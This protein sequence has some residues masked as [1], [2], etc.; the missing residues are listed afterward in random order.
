MRQYLQTAAISLVLSMGTLLPLHASAGPDNRWYIDSVC[1][2][3]EAGVCEKM[4]LSALEPLSQA[5]IAT[6]ICDGAFNSAMR[7]GCLTKAQSFMSRRDHSL[8]TG[9]NHFANALCDAREK[10][11]EER[12][13]CRGRIIDLPATDA[14]IA[15][16]ICKES[17]HLD[18]RLRCFKT[19]ADKIDDRDLKK[20]CKEDAVSCT[21]A[22]DRYAIRT[23]P[24]ETRYEARRTESRRTDARQ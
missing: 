5:Q 9:A 4:D 11:R 1:E 16:S 15:V 10:H 3:V 12:D 19:A 24:R 23:A 20:A 14:Q 17:T 13:D 6:A 2:E 7:F 8:E 18:A 22:F 21:V